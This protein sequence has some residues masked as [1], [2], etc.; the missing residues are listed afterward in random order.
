MRVV[1]DFC[2]NEVPTD[3]FKVIKHLQKFNYLDTVATDNE[4]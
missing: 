3:Q 4:K 2:G 1:N